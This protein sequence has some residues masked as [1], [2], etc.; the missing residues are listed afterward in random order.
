[1]VYTA[2]IGHPSPHALDITRKSGD[3]FGKV[4]APSWEILLEALA[5]FDALKGRD[6][7]DEWVLRHTRLAWWRYV[8]KY[9]EEMRASYRHNRAMWDDLLAR[10]R[11]VLT[12]YCTDPDRCHRTILAAAILPRLGATYLGEE[13]P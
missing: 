5:T 13:A 3:A 12:C 7:R 2:R 11:V 4:F 6:P 8:P 1:M 10:E 9:L